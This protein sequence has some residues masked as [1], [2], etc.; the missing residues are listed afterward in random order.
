MQVSHGPSSQDEENMSKTTPKAVRGKD[1]VRIFMSERNIIEISPAQLERVKKMHARMEDGATSSFN[2]NTLLIVASVLAGFGLV[3]NSTTSVIASMLVSPIM[4]P[5]IGLAYGSTIWDWKLVRK[6]MVTE[7]ISLVVCILIGMA[8]GAITGPTQL[9]NGWPTQVRKNK[10]RS[11]EDLHVC[12]NLL[13]SR[14]WQSPPLTSA[15]YRKCSRVGRGRIFL[16]PCPLLS[17][18][19]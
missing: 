4:G 12:G 14:L 10:R 17:F 13:L 6:S 2:Y 7:L 18:Q 15:T 19:A 5:V 9:S 3:S 8:V 1:I 11:Q 16:L